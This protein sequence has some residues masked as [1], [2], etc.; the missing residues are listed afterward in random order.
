MF[1]HQIIHLNI[2][3]GSLNCRELNDIHRRKFLFDN[4]QNSNFTIICLEE[5]KLSPV[6]DNRIKKEWH[7]QNY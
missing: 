6:D 7:N 2:G 1:S 3:T 4:L 5:T